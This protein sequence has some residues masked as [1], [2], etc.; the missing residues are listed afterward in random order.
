M[1][2]KTILIA[3]SV[4]LLLAGVFLWSMS[5]GP[6]DDVLIA[7]AIDDSIRAS[8]EGRP[9]GVLDNL[10]RDLKVQDEDIDNPAVKNFIENQKPDIELTN[11][12]P[13]M[14]GDL[15]VVTTDVIVTFG[16]AGMRVPAPITGVQIELQ[17][18]TGFKYFIFPTKKWKIVKIFSSDDGT[19]NL[20]GR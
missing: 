11:K 8:R 13:V 9:G 12:K 3:S 5:T 6:S 4:L 20:L 15:A 2:S 7:Q 14:R 19:G 17:K 1:R 18:E 10:S 16:L